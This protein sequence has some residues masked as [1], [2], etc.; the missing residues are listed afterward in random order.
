MKYRRPGDA[1]LFG[2][3]HA[4]RAGTR[5]L[6]G[7]GDLRQAAE[8]EGVDVSGLL[9]LLDRLVQDTIIPPRRAGRA[10]QSMIDQ[11][12]RLPADECDSRLLKWWRD[13]RS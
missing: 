7:D 2:L 10:L 9:W 8:S 12:A 1:D 5:L 11:G 6:S 13:N 4:A 3:L